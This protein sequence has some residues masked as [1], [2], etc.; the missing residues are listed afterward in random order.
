MDGLTSEKVEVRGKTIHVL[1]SG[2]GQQ[3]EN[4]DMNTFD[5]PL[6]RLFYFSLVL[7]AQQLPTGWLR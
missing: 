6:P 2:H 5:F 1:K 4:Q 7:L 3:V